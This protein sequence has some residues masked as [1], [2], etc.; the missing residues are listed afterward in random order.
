MSRVLAGRGDDK[1]PAVYAFS[2]TN[3]SMGPCEGWTWQLL[4]IMLDDNE[5]QGWRCLAARAE[6]NKGNVGVSEA[7]RVCFTR[8]LAVPCPGQPP[9]CHI[10]CKIAPWQTFNDNH[11][12]EFR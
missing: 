4:P 12:W 11:V 8:N 9:E 10:G 3:T 2:P 6:D 1:P 7:I 5:Q